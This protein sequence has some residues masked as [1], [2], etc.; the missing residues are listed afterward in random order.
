MTTAIELIKMLY[1]ESFFASWRSFQEVK[2]A[3]QKKGFNFSDP[4]ILVSLRRASS[5]GLLSK[6]TEDNRVKFSQKV[7]PQIKIKEKDIEELNSVLSEITKKKLGD[8]FQQ[9]IRELN[10]AFT[11]D[12]GNS[13]AFLLRKILEK[14]I[15]YVFAVNNKTKLLKDKNGN[16]MGLQDMINLCAKE[17]IKGIPVLLPKTT[18][19]IVGI[20]LLG[21]SAAHD[22][23]MNIEVSEINHQLPFWTIAIKELC[24]KL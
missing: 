17:T 6:K 4:L 18:K 9:D 5:R 13:A 24:D 3:L 19:E 16:F 22:Y 23:L 8:R 10:T 2:E 12:C 7:P 1:N 14:S 20:K 15:F 21:D 11:Y